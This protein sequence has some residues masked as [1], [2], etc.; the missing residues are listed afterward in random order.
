[1]Y[2]YIYMYIHIHTHTCIANVHVC[3]VVGLLCCLLLC[4]RYVCFGPPCLVLRAE[5]PGHRRAARLVQ[6]I[7]SCKI[8]INMIMIIGY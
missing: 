1:M 2:I 7:I 8:M 4:V 6:P 5:D 3:F